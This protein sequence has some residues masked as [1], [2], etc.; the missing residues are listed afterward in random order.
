MTRYDLAVIGSGGGARRGHPRHRAGQERGDGR[1]GHRWDVC[2]HRLCHRHNEGPG[3]AGC[4]RGWRYGDNRGAALPPAPGRFHHPEHRSGWGTAEQAT[5]AGI[6]C[7]SRVLPLENVPRAL[8][9]RDTRGFGKVVANADTGKIVG[10]TRCRPAR[11]RAGRR[12]GL[13]PERGYD[14]RAVAELWCPYLTM[15]EGIKI[16]CQSFTT[17]VSKLSCCAS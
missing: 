6:R 2:Q 9:N 16:A 13:H 5:E 11:R 1:A 10:V 3:P 12:R 15:T 8:V 7:D 4:R 14:R 17:D